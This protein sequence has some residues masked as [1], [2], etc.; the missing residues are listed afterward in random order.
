MGGCFHPAVKAADG[1]LSAGF[2]ETINPPTS[3][4]E[5]FSLA[6]LYTINSYWRGV[7]TRNASDAAVSFFQYHR[8]EH[9]YVFLA[10][11]P[12]GLSS[13]MTLAEAIFRVT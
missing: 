6:T 11:S 9:V 13:S 1:A 12:K 8:I 3:F 2:P 5:E 7:V 4:V 10:A